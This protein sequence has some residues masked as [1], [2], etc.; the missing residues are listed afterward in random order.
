[1]ALKEFI[2]LKDDLNFNLSMMAAAT[3]ALL[4]TKIDFIISKINGEP[5]SIYLVTII[6]LAILELII[7]SN[8]HHIRRNIKED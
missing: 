3:L 7:W 8:Y 4:L 5:Y 6:I 2:H 1:M